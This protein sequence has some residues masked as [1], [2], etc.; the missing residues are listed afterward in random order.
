VF[1]QLLGQINRIPGVVDSSGATCLPLA[2]KGCWTSTFQIE[3]Q[4]TIAD[5][6]LPSV[7]RNSIGVDY[8][9]TMGIPL[10][11]GRNFTLRDDAERDP[12]ALVNQRFAE[13]YFTHQDP[14]GKRIKLGSQEDHSRLATIVGVMGNVRREQLD[15]VAP[16]E[17]AEAVRQRGSTFFQ[18]VV[19]TRSDDQN[20]VIAAIQRA[21]AGIDSNIPVFDVRTMNWYVENET[22]GRR[23]PALLT[24]LFGVA[25]LLLAS[26]GLYGLLAFLV[27]QRTQEMGIRM[28]L[29]AK[30]GD[31]LWVVLREGL[32]LA[33]AG[34][35]IGLLAALA[36]SRGIERLL[37]ATS[38]T[39]IGTLISGS[40][41]LLTV[42]TIACL[43]P[44][45]RAAKSDPISALRME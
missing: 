12:A 1:D 28:A 24:I 21:A 32:R 25:A 42:T 19:R 40:G 2:G 17:V 41:L 31:V 45:C 9:A 39:D 33:I 18:L 15:E 34:L 10:L 16:P 20:E 27:A 23:L 36:L 26:I 3:G 6:D 14:I 13:K 8:L 38:G 37:F 7:Q 35:F 43:V 11:R 5:V 22:T 30:P 29:G 44:A 4:P